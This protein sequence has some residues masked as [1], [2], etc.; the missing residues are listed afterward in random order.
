MFLGYYQCPHNFEVDASSIPGVQIPAINDEPLIVNANSN[1]FAR[2]QYDDITFNKIIDGLNQRYFQLSSETLIRMINDEIA[3]V[4][5]NEL[6]N[7]QTSYLRSMKLVAGALI[8][9]NTNSAAVFQA[10]KSLIDEM[11][12]LGIDMAEKDLFENYFQTILGNFYQ[13]THWEGNGTDDWNNNVLRERLLLYSVY[14]SIGDARRS[15]AFRFNNLYAKCGSAGSWVAC[16][17]VSP[18]LRPAIYCGAVITDNGTVFSN[19]TRLLHNVQQEPSP[20]QQERSALMEGMACTHRVADLRKYIILATASEK[21]RPE[22]L[23]YLIRNSMASDVLYD[24]VKN[25]LATISIKPNGLENALK[26]M[27]YNWFTPERI[28]MKKGSICKRY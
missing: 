6:L 21:G 14:F 27:T 17:D 9:N 12:R 26:A 23:Q 10:A 4:H 3:L 13:N 5:R 16:N 19:M 2:V 25:M 24:I 1:T 20:S 18:D 8:N 11:I 28:E 7:G 15:A 22:D